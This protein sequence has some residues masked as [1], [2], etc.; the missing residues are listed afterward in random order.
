MHSKD[1]LHNGETTPSTDEW[2]E[3]LDV[4]QDCN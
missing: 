1:Q 4:Q 2:P 3:E